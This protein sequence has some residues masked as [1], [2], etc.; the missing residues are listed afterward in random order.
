M[1]V[2]YHMG[3]PGRPG[4]PDTV[5]TVDSTGWASGA[6]SIPTIA[7]NGGYEFKVPSGVVGAV[8]GIANSYR[9]VGYTSI[10]HALYFSRGAV[11]LLEAGSTIQ[12]LGTYTSSDKWIV[13]RTGS[14]FFVYK[15]GVM[16]VTRP[17]LFTGDF[18][19]AGALYSI[20]DTITDAKVITVAVGSAFVELGPVNAL[21]MNGYANFAA[22]E[23]SLSV[24]SSAGNHGWVGATLSGVKA[25]GADHQYSD[26]GGEI[27]PL[28]ALA[29]QNALAPSWAFADT[30]I[31]GLMSSS[32]GFTG[33]VGTVD[34]TLDGVKG[35]TSNK[36]YG[37][38]KSSA[39]SLDAFAAEAI[40]M[41]VGVLLYG[42]KYKLTGRIKEGSLTGGIM[43]LP[44][45]ALASATG[46]QVKI[47][48]PRPTLSASMT[49]ASVMRGEMDLPALQL[50]GAGTMSEVAGGVLNYAGRYGLSAK[51]GEIAILPIPMVTLS[52]VGAVSGLMRGDLRHAGHY[53]LDGV[54]TE[55]P[56][57][58][59]SITLP[60]LAVPPVGQGWL[61]GPTLKLYGE[62]NEVVAAEY[63]SYAINLSTGAVTR[64]TNYP[65]DNI[66]RFGNRFF[67][68]RANGLF[69]LVGNTDNGD[70]IEAVMTTFMTNF[71]SDN[72]KRVKWLYFFGRMDEGM[73]VTFTPDEGVGYTYQTSGVSDGTIRMHRAR[74]G[75]KITGTYYGF[76]MSNVNGSKFHIDRVEAIVDSTTRAM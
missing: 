53:T 27:G 12:T 17:M 76:T 43:K 22:V 20:G 73:N 50:S 44:K 5:L 34:T 55:K 51:F 39:F 59:W 9:G 33:V 69:E 21:A 61:V 47:T 45:L 58:I 14:N 41:N 42:G 38:V 16:V 66:L 46:T 57:T 4:T 31:P 32:F 48:I 30:S 26:A 63:E 65:F 13:Y 67:G 70:P 6:I 68:V 25:K 28:T 75:G 11:S 7:G 54:I 2:I 19:L 74:P 71:G 37:E 8:C 64:Y 56:L 36:P 62:I 35:L 52:G 40:E 1:T 23:L 60:T 10:N 24:S 15:N 3:T 18:I 49:F 29:E 72:L